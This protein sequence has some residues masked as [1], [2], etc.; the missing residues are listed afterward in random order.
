MEAIGTAAGVGHMRQ[1]GEGGVVP[2]H[3]A[4]GFSSQFRVFTGG[5][6]EMSSVFA[7]Q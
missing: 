2:G 5:Y 3:E 7:D 1:V 6:K 4:K